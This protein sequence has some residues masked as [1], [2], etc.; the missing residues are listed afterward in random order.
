MCS[1]Q[2][3]ATSS[4]LVVLRLGFMNCT[5]EAS[6]GKEEAQ[7]DSSSGK[8]EAQVGSYNLGCF[9]P[10]GAPAASPLPPFPHPHPEELLRS[11]VTSTVLQSSSLFLT[12]SL[13][14]PLLFYHLGDTSVQP[15]CMN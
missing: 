14:G 5:L 6:S 13:L 8:E 15:L 1:N 10:A 12:S 3:Q 11:T 9:S 7:V 4:A 2:N